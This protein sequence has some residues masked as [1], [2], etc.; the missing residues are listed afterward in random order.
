MNKLLTKNNRI[1]MTA[2]FTFLVMSAS[3]VILLPT[4]PQGLTLFL[5]VAFVGIIGIIGGLIIALG[6]TLLLFFSIGSILFW[7]SFTGASLLIDIPMVYL[8]MWMIMLLVISIITGR[9]S[10]ML[11]EL[12]V[13]NIEL[14]EQ[15]NTLVAIDPITGFDNK[16][17]MM[18]ELELEFSRSKR[19]HHTFSFLL[20]KVNHLDEF[21]K[22]YG[23]RELNNVL[24]HIS[25]GIY[26]STRK[27]DQK[28]R[29]EHDT[30]SILLTDT[31]IEMIDIVIDKI[32][33]QLK[34]FQLQ[35][36]KYITLSFEFGYTGFDH[37]MEDHLS[38]YEA[39]KEQVFMHGS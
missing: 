32:N 25:K 16:E 15:I 34:V 38:L 21:G 29:P 33:N 6:F 23:E 1:V 2:L 8:L 27:S 39:T 10:M 9:F 31:P 37:E 3:G 30:F 17:R 22:L 19:Y 20:I 24:L 28:F 14:R 5:L 18:L 7:T 26:Q 12:S 13:E 11:K 4:G 35:N 36:K